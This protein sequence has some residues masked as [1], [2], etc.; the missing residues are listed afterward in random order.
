MI[1]RYIF[2]LYSFTAVAFSAELVEGYIIKILSTS[3]YEIELA[4]G[5]GSMEVCLTATHPAIIDENFNKSSKK[6]LEERFINDETLVKFQ[7]LSINSKFQHN[8]LL[9][10]GDSQKSLNETLVSEGILRYKKNILFKQGF[11]EVESKARKEE[12]G[13]WAKKTEPSLVYAKKKM[14]FLKKKSKKL[15]VAEAD[16]KFKLQ[17]LSRKVSLKEKELKPI[18]ERLQKVK[19]KIKDTKKYNYYSNRRNGEYEYTRTYRK[20][21]EKIDDLEEKIS[22][23]EDELRSLKD[24]YR[25]KLQNTKKYKKEHDEVQ[26]EGKLLNKVIKVLE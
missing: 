25:S 22:K 5:T 16:S 9:F 24:N 23:L 11:E 18:K 8:G 6:D 2:L 12:L 13:M 10:I 26:E 21:K 17:P 3:Q 20:L 4:D 19:E 14:A 1:F 15:K 7:S